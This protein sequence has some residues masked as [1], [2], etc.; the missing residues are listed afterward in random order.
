MGLAITANLGNVQGFTRRPRAEPLPDRTTRESQAIRPFWSGQFN[1]VVLVKQRLGR[2]CQSL[3]RRHSCV[4][5]FPQRRMS[6]AH[7]T[8]PDCQR[9]RPS[10]ER[11]I[12]VVPFVRGLFQ[13][14]GPSA[15]SRFVI[16]VVVDSFDAVLTRRHWS[17]VGQESGKVIPPP[18]ANLNPSATVVRVSAERWRVAALNGSSPDAIFGRVASTVRGV[19]LA[20]N[21]AAPAAAARRLL[22]SQRG[23]R[24]ADLYAA[25]AC[26]FPLGLLA[27]SR[28]RSGHQQSTKALS[29]KIKARRHWRNSIIARRR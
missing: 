15:V 11:Q 29:K 2:F 20:V 26:A 10:V 14:G 8:S 27:D 1:T 7:F 28:T 12:T 5:T 21:L 17:H 25:V 6:Q 13:I 3:F 23:C 24:H 18:I 19:E 9:L 16:A 22:G 4:E